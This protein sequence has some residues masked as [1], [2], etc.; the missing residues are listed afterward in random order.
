MSCDTRA[1]QCGSNCTPSWLRPPAI[2]GSA[3]P[4]RGQDEQHPLVRGVQPL[5]SG[6]SRVAGSDNQRQRWVGARAIILKGVTIGDG[7]IITAWAVVTK[8]RSAQENSRRRPSARHPRECVLLVMSQH[9]GVRPVYD[10]AQRRSTRRD[11]MPLPSA[12]RV[13]GRIPGGARR[14]HLPPWGGLLVLVADGPPVAGRCPTHRNASEIPA[15]TPPN[16]PSIAP[17]RCGPRH[18]SN[19]PLRPYPR[20]GTRPSGRR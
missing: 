12:F 20:P 13:D 3:T 7:V 17:C 6:S 19:Q 18:R 15:R 9:R 11:L 4:V 16:R 2:G 5:P 14:G 8:G 1:R 10:P